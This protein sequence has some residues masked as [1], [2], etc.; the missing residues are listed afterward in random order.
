[1]SKI[2]QTVTM[3]K[4]RKNTIRNIAYASLVAFAV[5]LSAIL[6]VVGASTTSGNPATIAVGTK[7]TT[8]IPPM[9]NASIVK[10]FSNKE[11]QYNDTLKQW[12]IH[13]AIDLASDTSN[14]VLAIA[15]GTVTNVYTNYLEG[16][17]IEITHDNGIKSVYKSLDEISV[18]NGDYVAGGDVIASV[19]TS[20]ARELNTGAHLHFEMYQNDLAIN[21]NDYIDFSNK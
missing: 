13:K 4:S 3:D 15:N 21:P 11:L 2:Q 12:E 16:G 7:V 10:D 14:N 19:S 20:M 8:Y 6:I 18:K 9:E 1:M 5:I 17:V